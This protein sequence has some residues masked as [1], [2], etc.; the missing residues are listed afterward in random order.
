[1]TTRYAI[2]FTLPE[3]DPLYRLASSWLGYDAYSA[4]AVEFQSP[5]LQQS[6]SG[7]RR[8]TRGP[9]RYGLHATLKAPFRLHAEKTRD[10][11]VAALELFAGK[12]SAFDCAAL[13][14]QRV[15]DFLAL[16]PLNPC[17]KLNYLARNCVQHF[18]AFRAELTADE[19]QKRK[20][21]QLSERQ[22]HYLE[23][24]GYPYVLD[25]YR[26]HMTLTESLHGNTLPQIQ[27]EL[28]PV[29]KFVLQRP[30]HIHQIHLFQQD[31]ANGHFHIISS[32]PLKKTV[33]GYA[34]KSDLKQ[35][36]P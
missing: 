10:Q 13:S 8:Y 5:A 17:D 18:D 31:E 1:M 22:L 2:Y 23:K 25:E 20:P 29:F 7:Y 16:V 35:A 15:S 30:L 34:R 9:S 4:K 21:Q 6:L 26:F 27:H 3:T 32:H 12:T 24:W 19:I 11:L 14:I 28:E 36:C 33:A